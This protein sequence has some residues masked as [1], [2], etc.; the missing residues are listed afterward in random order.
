MTLNDLEIETPGA[1]FSTGSPYLGS[2]S[3]TVCPTA[4]KFSKFDNMYNRFDT[5]TDGQTDGPN[6]ARHYADT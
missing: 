6:I 3:R 2:Y 1:S 5:S 4:I